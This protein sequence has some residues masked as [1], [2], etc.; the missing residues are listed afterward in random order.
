MAIA[1]PGT[2]A[3][4]S[5]TALVPW[6]SKFAKYAQQ[7]VAMTGT[8][9]GNF[10]GTAGGILKIDKVA[11]PGNILEAIVM[12]HC[13]ENALYEGDF[14][15]QNPTPPIC[16]ALATFQEGMSG[17]EIEASMVPHEKSEERQVGPGSPNPDATGC[18]DCPHNEWGSAEKGRG[19]SCKN[20]RRLGLIASDATETG[21][22]EAKV[23]Y[24]KVP[25]TSLAA[26]D[27]YVTQMADT[28]RRPP[29]ALVTTIKGVPSPEGRGF[30]LEIGLKGR[31]EDSVTDESVFADLETKH[32]QVAKEIDFP[33]QPMSAEDRAALREPKTKPRGASRFTRTA[34]VAAAK[35]GR[36][37]PAKPAGRR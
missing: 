21:V 32:L 23:H 13:F 2:K 35:P 9:T 26:W 15:P 37:L 22:I 28:L 31:I 18:A 8:V 30:T 1:K 19:K 33:Y 4:A 11:V 25:P 34:P 3:K 14:D 10:V 20:Q 16:F 36:A 24:L 27:G 7:A 17:E 6:D 5:S 12:D 29:F